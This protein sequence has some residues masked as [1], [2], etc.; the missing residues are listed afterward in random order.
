[1]KNTCKNLEAHLKTHF[2]NK[3][4]VSVG[5]GENTLFIYLTKKTKEK[6][7]EIWEG[8]PVKTI[9]TGKFRPA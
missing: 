8:I 9:V 3:K 7:P 1:M 6:L 5:I 4:I 2:P